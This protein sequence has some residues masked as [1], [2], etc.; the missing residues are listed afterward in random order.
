MEQSQ[1]LVG[2]E[3][4]RKL[5]TAALEG[6]ADGPVLIAVSGEPGI[7][8]SS[9]LDELCREAERRGQ[10]ALTG[11]GAELERDVPFG[12]IADALD[13]YLA[14][15][16]AKRL[17]PLGDAPL[18]ELS[19]LLPSLVGL[20]ERAPTG[21]QDERYRAHG[22]AR[23]L[24]ELLASAQ[25]LVLALDDLH[26]ADQATVELLSFLLRRPPRGEVALVLAFREGQAP[27]RLAAA[28]D[29]ARRRGDLLELALAPLTGEQSAALLGQGVEGTEAARLH[30]LAGGN[31]FYLEELASHGV[32]PGMS[33]DP[34]EPARAG[35]IPA[36]VAAALE[37]ELGA[38][39]DTSRAVALGAAVAGASFDFELAAAAA[40]VGEQE[41]LSAIDDLLERGVLRRTDAP[42]RFRFRHPI[43]QGAVYEDAPAGWLVQAHARAAAALERQGA[44]APA[45][46]RHVERSAKVGDEG[47][48]ALLSE[49][50]GVAALRAPATAAHWYASALSLQPPDA[51]PAARLALLIPMAQALGYAG[52]LDRAR[53]TLDEVLAVLPADQLAVRGQVVAA[54][55]RID[56]LLGRHAAARSLLQTTLEELPDQGAPEGT[57]LKEQLAGACFFSGD[58]EGLRRWGGEALEQASGQGDRATHAATTGLLG[59]AEYM[60]GD[61]EAAREMLDRAE[62]RFAGLSDQELAPKLTALVWC[63]MCE[64]FLERFDRAEEMFE[65]ALA[66]GRSTGHGH[67]TTLTRV[68]Q[69]VIRLARGRLGEAAEVLD[70]AIESSLLTGNDQFLVWALWARCR[71]ALQAGDVDAAIRFGERGVAIAGDA[72]DPVSAFAGLH[73][74]EARYEAGEDPAACRDLALASLGGEGLPLVERAFQ[75]SPLE[76]LTRM[77][78]AAGDAERAARTAELAARASAGLGIGGRSAEAARAAAAVSL[79]AGRDEPAAARAL[80]AADLYAGAGI[81][82]EE[83]RARLLAGRALAAGDRDAAV[84]QL[85]RAR[86]QFDGHGAARYRDEAAGEL[87]SLGRRTTRP[88]R[89]QDQ[90]GDG[91]GALSDRE[92]EVA[93]LVAN[94]HTNREIASELYLSEKTIENH[95]SRI[96][97]KLGASK[98]AQV[99]AAMGAH[100]DP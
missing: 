22:A 93:E 37:R 66:V 3:R 57:A 89:A 54:C 43:V 72:H 26:W 17:T 18:A 20:G 63:G 8:K 19:Q 15:L 79:A 68:G 23:S 77:D 21:L 46:A 67:V 83:A 52:E 78:L 98:R 50:A 5:W 88:K 30:E 56:Q 28:L 44:P 27:D 33:A 94:G 84:E 64:I 70:E 55:A 82:I 60:V 35:A 99:A 71:T 51:E 4:E 32:A 73:L 25:P 100:R 29:D 86:I 24:L 16:P 36:P 31:P 58:F 6:I 40:G 85:E 61:L 62:G 7:G 9:V 48:S 45:R 96:F 49:A 59:C 74:A 39:P 53:E 13:D 38:L 92:R 14:G 69:G 34:S 11:R 42:R 97:G 90:I 87:R 12:A 76:L 91:V 65:R 75:S 80:E 10:L 1:E 81:A 47:A 95:M 2:R 41:A